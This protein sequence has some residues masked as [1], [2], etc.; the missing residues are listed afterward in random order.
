MVNQVP[1]KK[2]KVK[3]SCYA[4]SS[5]LR[6]PCDEVA[7][8]SRTLQTR[9]LKKTETGGFKVV[10]S[11]GISGAS[12]PNVDINDPRSTEE[13]LESWFSGPDSYGWDEGYINSFVEKD[14]RPPEHDPEA[15]TDAR[16]P[17]G[18]GVCEYFPRH[19]HAYLILS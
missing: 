14:L 9:K 17:S 7:G 18:K 8:K 11:R 19:L 13:I 4:P 16:K 3:E 2:R 5:H 1:F 6:S 12:V 15:A 10:S